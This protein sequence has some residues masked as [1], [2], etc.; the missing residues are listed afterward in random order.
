VVRCREITNKYFLMNWGV[1]LIVVSGAFGFVGSHL[2]EELLSRGEE[3]VAFSHP[4]PPESNYSYLR[5]H[6]NSSKLHVVLADAT[7]FSS[8][9]SVFKSSKPEVVYH[10]AAIA[11]HR[12]SISEPYLYLR[13][14]YLSVLNF[15]EAAR[16]VEPSPKVVFTSSSSVYGDNPSPLREDMKPMPKGP[17]AL[18]KF[19]G[20]ELCR[21]YHETYGLDCPVIRYFNVVGERCRG[22]IVFR[23]FANRIVSGLAVEVNGRF[24]DGE[25]RPAER[26][27]TY[28]KDAV[29][30][31]LLVGEKAD[32]F[33]VF[34]IGFGRP[35]SVLRVAELLMEY[36]GRRVEVVYRELKPHE[37]LVVYSD[38]SKA[39][40]K[41]GWSPRVDIE[42]M[43]RRY[44]EW[45]KNTYGK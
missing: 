30:G 18:S 32:G 36:L 14:N 23:I 22:N 3:V 24:F 16:V 25:F 28:V 21:F 4:S 45:F 6:P 1:G 10:L 33:E 11:S 15:L 27:F 26:D 44:A 43:T 17:Y 39:R 37:S 5:E 35:V 20:E 34:N 29:E 8:V 41:L 2:A 40:E 31:T 13:V 12:L 38:N 7:D 9:L 19:F 42:E